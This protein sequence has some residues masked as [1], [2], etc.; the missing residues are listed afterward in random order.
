MRFKKRSHLCNIKAQSEAAT[1]DGKAAASHSEDLAKFI[2]E[3]GHTKKQL[4]NADKTAFHWKKMP[5]RICKAREEKSLPGFKASKDRLTLL[6]GANAAGTLKLKPKLTYHS[7]HPRALR[8]ML[9]LLCLRSI[10]RT[11]MPA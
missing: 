9:N 5:S 10:H 1:A 2:S 11:P 4:F 6:L 3:G 8:I 7:K